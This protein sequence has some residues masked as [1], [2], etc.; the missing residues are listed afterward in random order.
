MTARRETAEGV[1]LGLSVREV[2]TGIEV[3]YTVTNHSGSAIVLYN[4]VASRSQEQFSP[5]NVYIDVAG[6]TVEISKRALPLPEGIQLDYRPVPLVT[7]LED[8][9]TCEE[10][11]QLDTP[12]RVWNPMRSAE[13]HRGT[14]QAI[15]VEP[16]REKRVR[17]L[18]FTLG[19]YRRTSGDT[20]VAMDPAHPEIYRPI[21]FDS[22]AQV[23]LSR[24]IE[25]PAELTVFDYEV[26]A[27]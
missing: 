1:T 10:R 3:T 4:R 21:R 19:F 13:L 23:L 8:A 26:T 15:R 24:G 18:G 27:L 11:I 20:F 6:S 22:R 9:H 17:R 16:A 14:T 5:D 12:I 25:L 7:L 2:A